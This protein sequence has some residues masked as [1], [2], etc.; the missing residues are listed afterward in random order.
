MNKP[1][2]IGT[3]LMNGPRSTIVK[4]VLTV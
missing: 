1:Q 3:K 2:I 4:S